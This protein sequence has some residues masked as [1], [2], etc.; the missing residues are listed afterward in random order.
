MGTS[1]AGSPPQKEVKETILLF[2]AW[3]L[4]IREIAEQWSIPGSRPISLSSITSAAMALDTI[5]E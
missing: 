3:S 1:G 2:W 5:H 4:E